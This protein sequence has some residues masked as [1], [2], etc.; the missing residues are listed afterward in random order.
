[1]QFLGSP[2][3]CSPM[4]KPLTKFPFARFQSSQQN[5]QT[6]KDKQYDSYIETMGTMQGSLHM[7]KDMA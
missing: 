3:L 1:M 2:S 6:P 4:K 5:G 7:T